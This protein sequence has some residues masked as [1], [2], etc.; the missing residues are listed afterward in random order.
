MRTTGVPVIAELPASGPSRRSTRDGCFGGAF[1]APTRRND[2]TAGNNKGGTGKGNRVLAPEEVRD[3][4]GLTATKLQTNKSRRAMRRERVVQEGKTWTPAALARARD[5]TRKHWSRREADLMETYRNAYDVLQKAEQ[6]NN[7]RSVVENST[8][9]LDETQLVRTTRV[10]RTVKHFLLLEIRDGVAKI[11][12]S[13][14]VGKVADINPTTVRRWVTE[15]CKGDSFVVRKRQ[16]NKREAHSH[17]DDE[18]IR[19]RLR[20]Y[21]DRR[22]YRR[23]KDEPRLRIADVPRWINEDLLKEEIAGKRGISRRTVHKWMQKLGFRWSRH[24]KCVYVERHNRPDIVTS[25]RS[26]VALL[27]SLRQKMSIPVRVEETVMAATSRR[28]ARQEGASDDSDVSGDERDGAARSE[29]GDDEQMNTGA[30]TGREPLFWP[31]VR[32]VDGKEEYKHVRVYGDGEASKRVAG[33]CTRVP[34]GP[35]DLAAPDSKGCYRLLPDEEVKE[36]YD[37]RR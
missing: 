15:F 31:A 32:E 14:E 16:H 34:F 35:R 19:S 8:T 24:H 11:E 25:R 18:D 28:E 22:L 23:K 29:T 37:R 7:Y 20:E 5:R 3:R 13:R 27:E 17:I 26:F 12:H 6:T 4:S 36:Y 10:I 21:I 9:M 1:A 2:N 30:T 33:D